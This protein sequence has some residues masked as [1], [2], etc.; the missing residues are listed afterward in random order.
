MAQI[1]AWR[2]MLENEYNCTIPPTKNTVQLKYFLGILMHQSDTMIH[3]YEYIF[4]PT[5]NTL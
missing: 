4:P 3:E 5:R 2:A 1:Q